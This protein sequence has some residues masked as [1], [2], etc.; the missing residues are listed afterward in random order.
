MNSALLP[1]GSDAATFVAQTE[2]E[3]H[4]MQAKTFDIPTVSVTISCSSS[5]RGELEGNLN[6]RVVDACRARDFLIVAKQPKTDASL[7]DGTKTTAQHARRTSITGINALAMSPSDRHPF[8][9]QVAAPTT[10]LPTVCNA[11]A[12]KPAPK[13]T[14]DLCDVAETTEQSAH[15]VPAVT[16]RPPS[17]QRGVRDPGQTRDPRALGSCMESKVEARSRTLFHMFSD[18][19]N[20]DDDDMGATLCVICESR[21]ACERITS[22]IRVCG[23][24]CGLV[25]IVASAQIHG[26]DPDLRGVDARVEFKKLLED[27]CYT[28]DVHGPPRCGGQPSTS[29]AC[30]PKDH[31]RVHAHAD[32]HTSSPPSAASFREMRPPAQIRIFANLPRS[33]A[34]LNAAGRHPQVIHAFAADASNNAPNKPVLITVDTMS[35]PRVVIKALRMAIREMD[36]LPSAGKLYAP[37]S[38]VI[39]EAS[40]A[41]LKYALVDRDQWVT[42]AKAVEPYAAANPSDAQMKAVYLRSTESLLNSL[43]KLTHPSV[44][45]R[46]EQFCIASTPGTDDQL[47]LD[48]VLAILTDMCDNLTLSELYADYRRTFAPDTNRDV[49]AVVTSVLTRV[50][51]TRFVG[52]S[53]NDVAVFLLFRAM[54]ERQNVFAAVVDHYGNLKP[55]DAAK[56]LPKLISA[57]HAAH[58]S[59]AEKDRVV[60]AQQV[61]A[62]AAAVQAVAAPANTDLRPTCAHCKKPGHDEARCYKKH[63]HLRPARA[64]KGD[65]PQPSAQPGKGNDAKKKAVRF[66]APNGAPGFAGMA[67][68][69]T[70]A[71]LANGK[72]KHGAVAPADGAFAPEFGENCFCFPFYSTPPEQATRFLVDSGASQTIVPDSVHLHNMRSCDYTIRVA[73]GQLLPCSAMGDLHCSLID[74]T[75]NETPAIFTGVLSTPHA[76]TPHALLSVATFMQGGSTIHFGS[77]AGD[78]YITIGDSKLVLAR[79]F[80]LWVRPLKDSI[81][82]DDHDESPANAYPARAVADKSPPDPPLQQAPALTPRVLRLWSARLN[83]ISDQA[84][85][86]TIANLP[87]ALRATPGVLR[88]QDFA[89]GKRLPFDGE[90]PRPTRPLEEIHCDLIGPVQGVTAGAFKYG[91]LFTCAFTGFKRVYGIKDRSEFPD[92][93]QWYV[94]EMGADTL[95]SRARSLSLA[96]SHLYL[97][98][99]R[100]LNSA[101]LREILDRYDMRVTQNP[102]PYTPSGNPIAERGFGIL[103]DDLKVL[104]QLNEGVHADDWLWAAKAAVLARNIAHPASDPSA[105]SPYERLFGTPPDDLILRMRV[106]NCRCAVVTQDHKL[107]KLEPRTQPARLLGYGPD[108][109]QRWGD[110]RVGLGW[111][112]RLDDGKTLVTRHVRFHERVPGSVDR[113]EAPDLPFQIADA[114]A[115]DA[116]EQL[117]DGGY[118][119]DDDDGYGPGRGDAVLEGGSDWL[120]RDNS[121]VSGERRPANTSDSPSTTEVDQPEHDHASPGHLNDEIVDQEDDHTVMPTPKQDLAGRTLRSVPRLDYSNDG[122]QVKHGARALLADLAS[123]H[124]VPATYAQAIAS[125]DRENWIAAMMQEI[126]HHKAR[127]TITVT[128][129]PANTKVIKAKWI[130]KIKEHSDGTVAS[131]KARIVAQGFRQTPADYDYGET[132]SPTLRYELL[133]AIIAVATYHRCPDAPWTIHA[134]DAVTAYLNAKAKGTTYVTV[135]ELWIDDEQTNVPDGMRLG[136]L[137]NKALNGL[138]P[139]GRDWYDELDATLKERGWTRLTKTWC[140]YTRFT[141]GYPEILGSY[142]DDFI[143]ACGSSDPDAPKLIINELRKSYEFK[144]LGPVE[145]HLGIQIKQGPDS[146]FL[147][148]EKY[149]LDAAREFGVTQAY[150]VPIVY[151]HAPPADDESAPSP[152]LSKTQASR[153]RSLTGTLLFAYNTCRPDIAFAVQMLARAMSKPTESDMVAAKRVLGYLY[154]TASHGITYHSGLVVVKNGLRHNVAYSDADWAT[155]PVSR[156]STSGY[157]IYL[158]GGPV[159]YRSSKQPIVANSSCE[160]EFVAIADT[161]KEVIY[162]QDIIAEIIG[163][164]PPVFTVYVD[165]QGAIDLS[166]ND[167]FHRRSKHIDVRYFFIRDCVAKKAFKLAWVPTDDNVADGFTK[168]LSNAKF[169]KFVAHF[170]TPCP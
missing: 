12:S 45:T 71:A 60:K 39:A 143:I 168:A 109:Y 97:D 3:S 53:E 61:S 150:P 132:F 149:I 119:D 32:E 169:S 36:L 70:D 24:D 135:P 137:V 154:G 48:K 33:P 25:A 29:T 151:H 115:D 82:G 102:P 141:K 10:K 20:A 67:I 18:R 110:I 121:P 49:S 56:E 74:A 144:H 15:H 98:G 22:H 138:I 17:V 42:A 90:F 101:A 58:R 123:D 62:R 142:V 104:Y 4:M 140:I 40:T 155:C 30:S 5:Q 51:R 21:T 76:Q 128:A 41:T 87:S 130:F 8:C 85:R 81:D 55:Q 92:A 86:A 89:K 79:D 43:L 127:D 80:T 6:A 93:L 63:P 35:Q 16:P 147:H 111:V 9:V 114:T 11:R 170:L 68:V 105:P 78:S 139:S 148:L 117:D 88:P 163:C 69:S 133:R 112:V 73:N 34:V 106:W 14:E 52:L 164:T 37:I 136:G 19:I 95:L 99:A 77:R 153:F 26:L 44:Q 94:R 152:L 54:M 159:S 2:E 57:M 166:K 27:T 75:G 96:G 47:T 120:L 165:N 122:T 156:K 13:T 83:H 113:D 145:R 134:A 162:V 107:N 108:G 100:E 124:A 118:V 23:A 1:P 146:T 126:A 158:A 50:N 103:G 167:V 38:T 66:A 84:V 7:R 65:K 91:V 64:D 46:L 125:P 131:Y 157:I 129:V 28:P 59:N 116:D 72:S 31:A 160:S 161:A